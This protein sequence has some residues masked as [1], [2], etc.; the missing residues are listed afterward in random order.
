[1]PSPPQ[2]CP[3]PHVPHATFP[4][5]PSAISPQFFPAAAH[6]VGVQVDPQT[7]A[8]PPAPQACPAGQAPHAS[9]PPQPS[10][11]APQVFPSASQVVGVQRTEAPQTLGM[12]PPPQVWPPGHPPQSSVAPQPS[13]TA[14]Q[15]FPSES[16]VAGEHAW[17]VVVR[18]SPHAKA[19]AAAA[20]TQTP[21]A[22]PEPLPLATGPPRHADRA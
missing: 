2:A 4:P 13:G 3:S 15:V 16:H 7:F 12:P 9:V 1:V 20:I 8:T 17:L 11:I 14:P 10:G 22:M 19:S 21:R 18:L 6:V 5:Q